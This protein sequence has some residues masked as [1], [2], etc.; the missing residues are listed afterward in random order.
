VPTKLF[1]VIID[2]DNNRASAYVFP[3]EAL[4]VEDLEKHKVTIQEIEAMTGINF[5]PKLPTTQKLE[6]QKDW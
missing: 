4:P 3:N 1:K 6:Q 2:L 5:N